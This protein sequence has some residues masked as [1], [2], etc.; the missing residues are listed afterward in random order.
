MSVRSLFSLFLLVLPLLS[1]CNRTIPNTADQQI[2]DRQYYARK[3]FREQLASKGRLFDGAVIDEPAPDDLV[4]MIEEDP[5]GEWQRL[6]HETVEQWFARIYRELVRRHEII[7]D[8]EQNLD[9]LSLEE[10]EK[11]TRL[12]ESVRKSEEL[13]AMLEVWEEPADSSFASGDSGAGFREGEIALK[14]I[15]ASATSLP[16]DPGFMIHLVKKGETLYS[17]AQHYYGDGEMAREILL[18]NQGWIRSPYELLAGSGIILFPKDA[19]HKKQQVVDTY[20]RKLE[21]QENNG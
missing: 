14:E 7:L 10:S 1:S 4:L 9:A 17:I 19:Q 8:L 5:M 21:A 12:Q 13:R 18:W 6:P 3:A 15:E 16:R 2:A 20:L 11:V